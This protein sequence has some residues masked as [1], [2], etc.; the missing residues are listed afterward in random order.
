MTQPPAGADAGAAAGTEDGV[1]P[2][3]SGVEALLGHLTAA[4]VPNV[5]HPHGDAG[6]AQVIDLVPASVGGAP[7][8]ALSVGRLGSLGRWMRLLHRALE[9][10]SHPGPWQFP[11]VAR[12]TIITHNDLRP[13]NLLFTGDDLAAVLGWELAGP[14]SPLLDLAQVAWT[15]VPL[16]RDSHAEHAAARLEVLATAYGTV[17]SREIYEAIEPR[18]RLTLGGDEPGASAEALRAF[19]ERA[20]VLEALL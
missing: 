7:V 19:R 14:S 20:A 17:T 18:V 9:S 3:A 1:P 5:P 2:W 13:S 15:C 11:G 12:A 16:A 4:G 8:D 6:G 10:F